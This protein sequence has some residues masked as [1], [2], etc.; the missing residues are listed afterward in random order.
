MSTLDIEAYR[1]YADWYVWAKRNLSMESAVCHAAAAAATEVV[2]AGGTREQAIEAAR[3]SFSTG[4]HAVMD[5]GD[6]RRRTYAE[7]FDWARRELGGVREQQHAA[8]AAALRTLDAGAGANVAMANARAAAGVG[9]PDAQPLP[10]APPPPPPPPQP[11]QPPLGPP[12]YQAA[13]P[14]P[15]YPP[16][17][18]TPGYAA[19]PAYAPPAYA[20]APQWAAPPAPYAGFGRRLVAFL[21]DLLIGTAAWL[22]LV[23]AFTLVL[24]A[25]LLAGRQVTVDSFAKAQPVW[26]DLAYYG[27]GV[28]MT[29]LYYTL[30]EASRWQ[31]TVGKLALGIKVTDEAGARISW[32]RANARYWAKLLSFLIGAGGFLM[33]AFTQRRQGLHDLL[34]RT[35][36]VR[37][38]P[39]S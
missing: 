2:R 5:T 8:A 38:R 23:V 1:A 36:V 35:L 15:A 7:W 6:V 22:A 29:W 25:V 11:P 24:A 28:V 37:R 26:V 16:P 12:A 10:P 31:G 33:I 21:L 13:A 18:Y 39:P 14:P 30:A 17:G 27:L 9:P 4:A 19:A 20:Y 3:R 34:A 32:P